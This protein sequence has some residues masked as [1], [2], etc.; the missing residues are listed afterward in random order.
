MNYHDALCH[1]MALCAEE[2]NAIFMGQ[3][4]E[5]PSTTMS[6]TFRDVPAH[7]KLEMPVAEELQ[8]GMAL[9]MSLQGFLPI[10]IFPRWNF[11]LRAAD[12]LVNHLDRLPIY[13]DG[14]YR[15]RVIIRTAIPSKEPFNPQSQHDDDFSVAFR[16]MLRTIPVR[17]IEDAESVVPFYEQALTSETSTILVEKSHLYRDARKEVTLPTNQPLEHVH[18]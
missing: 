13:S 3:G 2:W 12:Q 18:G 7:K 9:G 1:A 4:V 17:V 14:G 15:P 10:C 6:T 11:V 5:Y 16:Y 8:M